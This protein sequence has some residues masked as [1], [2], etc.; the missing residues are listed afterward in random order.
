M[1][2][3][4]FRCQVSLFMKKINKDKKSEKKITQKTWSEYF[5]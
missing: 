5:I 4:G 2:G 3:L 1:C